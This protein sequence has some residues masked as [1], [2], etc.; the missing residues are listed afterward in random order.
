MNDETKLPGL[1]GDA[2]APRRRVGGD[3]LGAEVDR[4]GDQALAVGPDQ[5]DPE[6]GGQGHQLVL[7]LASL[8][9]GLA[10]AGRGHEGG[11]DALGRRRPAAGRG[12]PPP[13][14]RR[15]PG[16]PRRRAGRRC[17]PPSGRRGPRPPPGWWRRPCPGSRRLRMLWR[18]TK[19]NLPGWV[20]APATT[21]AAGLEQGEEGVPRSRSRP[22]PPRRASTAIG[23]PSTTSSGFRSADATSSRST[24]TRGEGEQDVLDR[25][26]GPRRARPGP[27]RAGPGSGAGRP[28]RRRRPG[29]SGRGGRRRRRAPRPGSRRCRASPSGRTGGPGGCPAIS[30][31]FA[32]RNG[33]TSTETVPSSGRAAASSSAAAA[34]TASASPRLSRTRPRSVLWAMPSPL[35]LATTG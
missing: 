9:A 28:C 29:R 25:G 31:R 2:D 20:D 13:G 24:A 4:G 33:A 11:A 32:F 26:R 12:W 7:G 17:R 15:R 34:S 30:S 16:R 18:A 23:F 27:R 3:D 22:A 14:C 6:L 10:V 1:A 8:R 35:S 21:I 19:P 5:E